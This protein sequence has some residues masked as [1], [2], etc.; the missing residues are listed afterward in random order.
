MPEEKTEQKP[1]EKSEEKKT[2]TKEEKKV[3]GW[4]K[5]EI[6]DGNA[7]A[8]A[9]III[10]RENNLREIPNHEYWRAC[11]FEIA[12]NEFYPGIEKECE[13][14]GGPYSDFLEIAYETRH[15]RLEWAIKWNE[16]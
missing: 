5:G 2:E 14:L 10:D 1:E 6:H 9:E 15:E 8:T 12:L 4:S 16:V 7:Q 3:R 13:T 11:D